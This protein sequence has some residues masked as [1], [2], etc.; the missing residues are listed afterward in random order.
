MDPMSSGDRGPTSSGAAISWP[1]DR[2]Y[3]WNATHFSESEK[4]AHVKEVKGSFSGMS[5]LVGRLEGRSFWDR[6]TMSKSN[7]H[8]PKAT[9]D[10]PRPSRGQL[11]HSRNILHES[12]SAITDFRAQR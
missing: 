6:Y 1:G 8:S 4:R 2:S 12:Q 5:G 9:S 7:R 11:E 3:A 10:H